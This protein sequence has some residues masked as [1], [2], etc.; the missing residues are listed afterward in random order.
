MELPKKLENIEK[1]SDIWDKMVK[2]DRKSR[3]LINW[4]DSPLVQEYYLKK[5]KV[6]DVF[7]SVTNFLVWVKEKYIKNIPNYGLSL[8]C[9]D[10]AL[11]RHAITL[12]ICSK[13]GCTPK[14]RQ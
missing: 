8:G 1:V 6:K 2:I 10:G 7:I 13:Y 11:E 3:G 5:F 9:A 14:S 4:L 12:N